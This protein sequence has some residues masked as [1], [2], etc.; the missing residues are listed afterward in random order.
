M[1]RHF[2]LSP[3]TLLLVSFLAAGTALPGE[4]RAQATG[5]LTGTVTDA[6]TAEPVGGAVVTLPELGMRTLS[7]AGGRFTLEG[8]P[9]GTHEIRVGVFGRRDAVRSVTVIADEE[10]FV[11]LRMEP[12]A[13]QLNELVVTGTAFEESPT[14]LPYAVAVS[15][16]RT[17]AEQGS[18][19][20][21]DFFRNLA[22]SA[23][24]LGD[25]QGWYNTRPATAVSETTASV[26]LRGIGASRTLVLLNGRRQVYL[27][28]RISGGRFVDVNAFPSIALDRIEVVKEGA[29]AIYGS[30]AVAGVANFLT[31]GDFEGV[32]VSGAH[33]YYPGGGDTHV[34]AIWGTRLGEDAHAVVST[35]VA[36]TQELGP[37]E[38]DWA[39]RSFLAGTGAWSYTGN[40]GAFLFPKLTGNETKE[41]F[42]KALSD[43]QFGG[44]V[45]VDPRCADFG[46]HRENETCRFRYQPWDNLLQGS[47]HVRTFAEVNGTMGERSRYHVEALWA[48]AAIP[49][50]VTTPSYP[51]ISPYNGAQVIGS[52]HPGRRQFCQTHGQSAGFADQEACLEND[53]YFYGRLVGNSG[54]A[55]IME[56]AGR[57]LRFAGSLERDFEAFGGRPTSFELATSYSRATGNSNLPAEYAYRKFLAF[58][59]FGG[60]DCGVNVVVD[61]SSPSG[62]AL[63]PLG[64]KVAGEGSCKYYNPFSSAHEHSAQPGSSFEDKA[65]PDY[66]PALANGAELLDWINEEVNLDNYA[67]LVVADA[68]LKGELVEDVAEYAVGYQFRRLNVSADPN[69]PGDLAINPC[70]VLGDKSCLE[71]AGAFTFTTGHYSYEAA[72]TVNR[73]FLESRLRFGERVDAQAA[74]NYEFHGSV[75][76]FDPKL[77]LRLQ[78]AEPLALRASLQ[79]TFRTPSADDLNEDRS[80][81]LEY[82]NEAGIYKAVDTYGNAELTP[83]RAFT[84]NV[85]FMLE[86]AQGRAALDY[87]NYNFRDVIDVL[88]RGGVTTLYSE[89]GASRDAVKHLI[90]CPDGTGTGT[91]PVEAVERIKVTNVNWPGIEMSGVD[92]HASVR[93]LAGQAILSLGIDG[94]YVQKF[95]VKELKLGD[96]VLFAEQ[97]AAGALNEFNPVAPPLP[98]LKSR[99]SAGY[100]VGDYSLVNY[101]NFVSGYTNWNS[102]FRDDKNKPKPGYEDLLEVD[103]FPTWDLSFLRRPSGR[104]EVA[105]SVLNVAGT[106]PPR[107]GWEQ[108]YDAFTHSPKGRRIKLSM[109]YRMAN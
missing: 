59:G 85:G 88:P 46:G 30:D 77:A 71:K 13:F 19:T 34:G 42:V 28:A 27:P 14:R 100:H 84:Y 11:E 4:A 94:T 6:A 49:Q 75:S 35:E 41:E 78:V 36:A 37:A 40:P 2:P 97:D 83:E 12:D 18:P 53:W 72:Q 31:R 57:T 23:G 33:E 103:P 44:D 8:V 106:D 29:S 92:F 79:T 7:K 45:F 52:G 93:R 43:A 20:A 99:L 66:V 51:P 58:R 101:F 89:G 56:R 81:S 107:V 62:M 70:P 24:V 105:L 61:P 21:V 22:A 102:G 3:S 10:V 39:L 86:M 98:R 15:G 55:R 64:G 50:W 90:T 74:A 65:N 69:D 87:W 54:P 25:R 67:D 109:T 32:E 68:M 16:R 9:A 104:T 1:P 48:Q 108:A 82:V 47:R 17:M 63:G 5:T 76:S 95:F 38:R 80:T 26:N 96:A 73:F 60:A 91:C